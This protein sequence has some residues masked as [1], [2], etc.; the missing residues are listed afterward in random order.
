MR[1][2]LLVPVLLLGLLGCGPVFI[3][4]GGQLSG[5]VVSAPADWSFSDEVDIVQLE[6]N[7]ADPYSV[8]IWATAAADAIYVAG[9]NGSQWIENADDDPLVRLRIEDR[10]YEL[11]AI[12]VEDDA[13][14]DVLLVAMKKKYDFDPEPE[15]RGSARA[16]RLVPRGS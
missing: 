10:V 16:F 2:P 12:P 14:I 1:I 5:E 9:R 7:S 13:E 3:F 11:R 8:N 4:P 6:T 15:D